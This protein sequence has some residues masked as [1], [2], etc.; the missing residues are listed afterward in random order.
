MRNTH[1]KKSLQSEETFEHKVAVL[2]NCRS[3]IRTPASG[4]IDYFSAWL[5]APLF[6]SMYAVLVRPDRDSWLALHSSTEESEAE[7]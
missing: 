1:K 2:Y 4:R 7:L 3:M 5:S 6:S